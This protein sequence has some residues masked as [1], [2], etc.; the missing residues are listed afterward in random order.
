[1]KTYKRTHLPDSLNVNGIEMTVN[2]GISSGMQ[3]NGT[4]PKKIAAEL[5]KQNRKC[6]LVLVLEK[7]LRGR[8]DLHG[9]LYQPSQWIYT[10]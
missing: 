7:N 8:T 6:A 2:I 1:M 10:N 3:R 5:K 9:R 4:H